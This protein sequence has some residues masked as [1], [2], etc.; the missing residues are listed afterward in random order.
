[1]S[2]S[3]LDGATTRGPINAWPSTPGE[4]AARWNARTEEEREAMVRAIIDNAETASLCH[5]RHGGTWVQR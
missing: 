2:E 5:V 1:M 3:N 4:F